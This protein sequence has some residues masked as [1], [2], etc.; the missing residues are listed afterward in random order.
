MTA[1]PQQHIHIHMPGRYQQGI[2][3]PGRNDGMAVREADAQ[4]AMRHDLGERQVG[5]FGVEVAL[6]D[7]EVGRQRAQVVVCFLV[8][9][10]AETEDRA[11]FVGCEE[12]FELIYKR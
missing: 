7:L 8:G 5:R 12:F 3:V 2:G 10:V 1:P 11:D 4:R 6:D 9:Q